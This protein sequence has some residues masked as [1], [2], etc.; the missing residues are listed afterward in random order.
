[1]GDKTVSGTKEWAASNA[2]VM[3]GCEHGCM[4]CYAKAMASRFNRIPEGGWTSPVVNEKALDKN[5]GKRKGTIMFPTTHDITPDNL[6]HVSVVLK[7]MLEAGNNVLIVSKPHLECIKTLCDEF[8]SY[9]DQILFRFTIGSMHDSILKFWEPGAP[10]C[11]ERVAALQYAFGKEFA[12]SVSMEPMLDIDEDD[13]VNFAQRLT[14]HVTDAVWLGK[15]NKLSERLKRNG[16]LGPNAAAAAKM[17]KESQSDERIKSL[18]SRLKDDP[19]VK[20]KESI[21]KVV[22]IEVPTEA[23]LDV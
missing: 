23:G 9:R 14:H 21:K 15:V 7:K 8:E 10:E 22:G 16:W 1:M 18:Y 13:I 19:K 4:Y 2:N 3:I 11:G 5:Y 12:T 20:W 17:L 6:V